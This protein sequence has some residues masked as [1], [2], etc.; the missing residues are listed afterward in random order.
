MRRFPA[1]GWGLRMRISPDRREFRCR[2]H[3]R[4]RGPALVRRCR[5]ASPNA[6]FCQRNV[7]CRLSI[8]HGVNLGGEA[9]VDGIAAK[10]AVG[11]E[12][13]V[14]WRESFADDCEVADL[15]IVRQ[16]G[17]DSVECGL[18]GL[19]LEGADYE[20]AKITAAVADDD[21]VLRGGNV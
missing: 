4:A 1:R 3:S 17:I 12:H 2:F 5:R 20:R 19:R 9:R 11:S 13:A 8:V 21:D 14:F 10:L 16:A 6:G 7:S 15:P 18:Y